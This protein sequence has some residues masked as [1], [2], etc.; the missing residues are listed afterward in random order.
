MIISNYTQTR[1]TRIRVLKY[2][3]FFKYN[4]Q[5]SNKYHT[6]YYISNT[7]RY[8]IRRVQ[9]TLYTYIHVCHLD[10]WRV[11]HIY[12]DKWNYFT[13]RNLSVYTRT[14]VSLCYVFISVVNMYLWRHWY[15]RLVFYKIK[16]IIKKNYKCNSLSTYLIL[17]EQVFINAKIVKM[18]IKTS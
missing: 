18:K 4:R 17:T 6:N 8:F 10:L 3:Y 12:D 5:N 13:L 11:T 14:K 15:E 9:Y 2:I 1:C 16:N 7:Y